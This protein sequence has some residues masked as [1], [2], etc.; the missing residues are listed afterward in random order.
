MEKETSEMAV[1]PALKF[2]YCFIFHPLFKKTLQLCDGE[3]ESK[4]RETPQRA[5]FQH[6]KKSLPCDCFGMVLVIL[7]G[8]KTQ[9][10]E[11]HGTES[12]IETNA[13]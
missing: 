12:N 5:V 11:A 13:G 4:K 3:K 8:K 7:V 6:R 2:F 9:G 1:R 10:G